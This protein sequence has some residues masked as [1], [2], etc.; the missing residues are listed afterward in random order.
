MHV[1]LRC[2]LCRIG[3]K[4]SPTAGPP[5][6][7]EIS[8]M[9]VTLT[10]QEALQFLMESLNRQREAKISIGARFESAATV[11]GGHRVE[12]MQLTFGALRLRLDPDG[13]WVAQTDLEV[14]HIRESEATPV[15]P[16]HLT[17]PDASGSTSS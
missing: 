16:A 14:P 8:R 7:A 13:T 11:G 1:Q 2:V 4:S 17:S 12:Q 5:A 15:P 6:F 9:Q 10:P 3:E